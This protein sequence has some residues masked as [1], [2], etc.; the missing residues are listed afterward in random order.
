MDVFVNTHSMNHMI[1]L[2]RR[3]VILCAPRTHT[4]LCC[5][6][7]N[8]QHHP[9][10]PPS[11]TQLLIVC[12][13]IEDSSV[14]HCKFQCTTCDMYIT[15]MFSSR[16]SRSSSVLSTVPSVHLHFNYCIACNIYYTPL[17]VLAAYAVV[18]DHAGTSTSMPVFGHYV[19][20]SP[21]MG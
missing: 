11:S 12:N 17:E 19:E 16:M 7:G 10:L 8:P 21:G 14:S 18:F 13:R 9:A 4:S 15:H 3:V 2:N 5:V 20:G 1:T 6:L